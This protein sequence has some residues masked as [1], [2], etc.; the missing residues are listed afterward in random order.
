MTPLTAPRHRIL[1]HG[2][3]DLLVLLYRLAVHQGNT[4]CFPALATI[5]ALYRQFHDRSISTRTLCRHLK[6]LERMCL[7]VRTRRHRRGR[8]G[9]LILRSTLYSM[10][11]FGVSLIKGVVHR[12]SQVVDYFAVTRMAN[13]Q[14]RISHPPPGPPRN[15]ALRADL[16]THPPPAEPSIDGSSGEKAG[17]IERMRELIGKPRPG[18]RR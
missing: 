3:R 5:A 12:L 11:R 1:E 2:N 7:I 4:Y 18:R 14:R 15:E 6:H 8:N 13:N 17:A 9:E 10:T 16:S